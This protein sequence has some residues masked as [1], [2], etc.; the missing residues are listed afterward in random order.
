MRKV[1]VITLFFVACG[2]SHKPAESAD[3][4]SLES[5][6]SS[7]SEA[8]PEKA[9]PAAG[10]AADTSHPAET[11]APAPAASSGT[12]APASPARP[13]PAVT[14]LI[15]GKPFSP[16]VAR[17][18]S[19]AQKDGRVLLTFDESHTDCSSATTAP[20]EGMLTMLVPWENG[21]KSDLGALKRST[22]KKPGGEIAF[23]RARAGG[24]KDISATFKPAGTVTIIKA[25]SEQNATGQLKIDLT[26]GD[27]MLA[28][29]LD[30]LLCTAPK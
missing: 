27:Y 5:S 18:L 21:Y 26:S 8:A 2:G 20:G 30:V 9:E 29:D 11:P 22:P 4:S 16:K 24:K 7:K 10:A 1:L 28:G 23:S 17:V 6:G 3:T 19:K 12:S 14:G 13:A 25:P 15:D